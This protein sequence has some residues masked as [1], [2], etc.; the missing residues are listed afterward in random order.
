MQLMQ[1]MQPCERAVGSCGCSAA[2]EAAGALAG[3]PDAE[4]QR[5]DVVA[6]LVALARTEP[7]LEVLWATV[8]AITSLCVGAD[9][10]GRP[11]GCDALLARLPTTEGWTHDLVREGERDQ[12]LRRARRTLARVP[13][14]LQHGRAVA[15][16]SHRPRRRLGRRW[17]ASERRSRGAPSLRTRRRSRRSSTR[18]WCEQPMRSPGGALK[19]GRHAGSWDS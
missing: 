8:S 10:G 5:S 14:T 3:T 17:S 6:G 7:D 9:D 4:S 1:L 15:G 11:L 2:P 16:R 18:C 19:A 13:A 12:R